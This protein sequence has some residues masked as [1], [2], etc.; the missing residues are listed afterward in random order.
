MDVS[1]YTFSCQ[2]AL[3]QGLQY[4][5]SFG[6]RQL[7]VEHVALAMLR[8]GLDKPSI[9]AGSTFPYDLQQFLRSKERFYGNITVQFGENL[10]EAM[11]Y[12][13]NKA[14]SS[15]VDEHLFW[16]ALI[17]YSSV[18]Q[19]LLK[20]SK[21][22]VVKKATR[23]APAHSKKLSSVSKRA[24]T[25]EV[26]DSFRK[27][28]KDSSE[29][30]TREVPEKIKKILDEY[31]LDLTAQAARDELD[32]II[33]RDLETRRALEIL[34]RKKKNNPVLIGEPGVGKTAIAESLAQKII[35]NRVPES[36]KGK[37]I[38]SLSL[39]SI[40]AGARMRGEFEERMQSLIAAIKSCQGDIIVFIDEIHMIVGTGGAEG[41]SDLANLLKPALARGELH[42]LG[43][44]TLDE[45]RKYIEKDPALERRFQP[46][47][48]NEPTR[49]VA[50][51]VMRG[52]K[53]KYEIHHGVRINDDA[54]VYSVDASIRYLSGRRL[55]DKAID[56]LDE[57]CSRLRLQID[58][59]PVVMDDLRSQIEQYQ[60]EKKSLPKEESSKELLTKLETKISSIK[61]EYKQA[62]E[63]WREHQLHLENVRSK[64]SKKQELKNM[65]E[66][67]KLEG[68]FELAAKLSHEEIPS[69]E[70]DIAK[71]QKALSKM[72]DEY[73][74][75]RQVVG[76]PEIAEIIE[77]W[78]GIPTQRALKEESKTLIDL[79]KRLGNRVFGQPQALKQVAQAVRRSRAGVNDPKRPLGVFLFVG[80]TGVGKTEVAKALAEELFDDENRMV[81]LDMSEYMEPHNVSRLIGSPPGYIGYDEGGQ[82][83]E[84]VRR[85]PYT[86]V[87]F[88]ELEK[89]HSRVLDILLQIFEDGR[90]TDGKGRLV[91]FRNVLII[92][93]SNIPI[94]E[95]KLSTEKLVLADELTRQQLTKFLRPEFVGRVDEIV[96]FQNLSTEHLN[97]LLKRLQKDLNSRLDDRKLR[98]TV[99][100]KLEKKLIKMASE[101]KFGGRAL[102]RAFQAFV[103]NQVSDKLLEHEEGLKGAWELEIISDT[104]YQWQEKKEK[105]KPLPAAS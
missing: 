65:F 100:A 34:G 50:L 82:L 78:T 90:L 1:R 54:L 45:Y 12:A 25:Q 6:H 27:K 70:A 43:A 97:L 71:G 74:W 53:S 33:G 63:L 98:I 79:E 47:M 17:V 9:P 69:L 102:R 85:T 23:K 41:S 3:H 93:T 18:L 28:T 105:D 68:D 95:S 104:E 80:Q 4:A 67:A 66:N 94:D 99:G 16:D 58:S 84:S 2:R 8:Q 55:P 101:G 39:S 36:V 52:L 10:D 32:P 49:D 7:E 87:L 83:S 35:A 57:A 38:L 72:Q 96:Q 5:R 89:A 37:R 77:N 91:D 56:L 42:C 48:V 92:M 51:T 19:Q 21:K 13:E 44:T 103:V 29:T 88:D 64:E 31:T 60:I 62:E 86:V 24:K 11:D 30:L 20:D 15:K 46:V 76:A 59:M 61:K 75:L 73:Q 81:R 40:I 14:Q 22:L 26:S